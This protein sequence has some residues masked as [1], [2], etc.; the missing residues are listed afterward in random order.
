MKKELLFV[1]QSGCRTTYSSGTDDVNL[2]E[3]G[4]HGNDNQK[5]VDVPD[6][7]IIYGKWNI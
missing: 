2:N 6:H 7:G 5:V 1:Y 3:K 4:S